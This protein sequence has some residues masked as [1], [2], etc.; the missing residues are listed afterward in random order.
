MTRRPAGVPSVDDE[1][2]IDSAPVREDTVVEQRKNDDLDVTSLID[3][4]VVEYPRDR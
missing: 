4:F 1:A 3:Y 2:L